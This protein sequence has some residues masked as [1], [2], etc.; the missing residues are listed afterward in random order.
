M[1]KLSPK[2]QRFVAEYMI[3]SNATQA[4]IRAGYSKRT[5]DVKGSQLLGRVRDEVTKRKIKLEA[6]LEI[7]AEKI[8]REYAKLAFSDMADYAEWEKG[9]ATLKDSKT[10][11]SDQTAA[12]M[13]VGS[14]ARGTKIKLHDKKGALDSLAKNLGLIPETLKNIDGQGIEKLSVD[15]AKKY[16]ELM[17]KMQAPNVQKT[18]PR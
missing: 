18:K 16:R 10:L 15:E 13:E 2:Q 8:L 12:V 11:T 4:A 7:S 1:K 17:I 5:A 3:D 6:K 14:D 9:H